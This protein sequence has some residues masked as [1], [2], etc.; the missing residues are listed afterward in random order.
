MVEE[1]S[2]GFQTTCSDSSSSHAC[3]PIN[4]LL[5]R[6]RTADASM[7]CATLPVSVP[8]LHPLFPA[9]THTRT[10]THTHTHTHTRTHPHTHTHAHT[11][12]HTHTHT[13]PPTH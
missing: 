4:Y 7:A 9:H 8:R 12:T 5:R 6:K 13:H 3:T 11:H 10:H 1:T 2:A